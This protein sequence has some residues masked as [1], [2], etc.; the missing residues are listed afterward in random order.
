MTD[1]GVVLLNEICGMI[2]EELFRPRI[3]SALHAG[4]VNEIERAVAGCST[5]M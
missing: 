2:K 1:G 4:L 3:T 5:A